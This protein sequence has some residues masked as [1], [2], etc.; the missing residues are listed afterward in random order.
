MELVI[1]L[2][3]PTHN[4]R[5]IESSSVHWPTNRAQ[6]CE[7]VKWSFVRHFTFLSGTRKQSSVEF[8]IVFTRQSTLPKLTLPD[9]W[10]PYLQLITLRVETEHHLLNLTF[11]SYS[12]NYTQ[13]FQL[14]ASQLASCTTGTKAIQILLKRI[15]IEKRSF[16][17]SILPKFCFRI[18][19]CKYGEM[20]CRFII[21]TLLNLATPQLNHFF[22]KYKT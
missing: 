18:Q 2:S 13:I 3:L 5:V 21:S 15:M 6:L 7:T 19:H 22:S 16:V 11:C 9:Q 4:I 14:C 10:Y 17:E 1:S 8:F 20:L 12:Y